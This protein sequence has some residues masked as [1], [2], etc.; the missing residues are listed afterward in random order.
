M[1]S[2]VKQGAEFQFSAILTTKK[3]GEVLENTVSL[4][5]YT[6]EELLLLIKQAGFANADFYG[7]FNGTL[8]TPDSF[9][10]IGVV[11]L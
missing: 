4:Y 3:T 10:T 1:Y 5:P 9:L 7:S 2:S 11:S 6:M 8:W